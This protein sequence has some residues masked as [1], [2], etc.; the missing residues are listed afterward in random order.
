MKQPKNVSRYFILS[1]VLAALVALACNLGVPAPPAETPVAEQSAPTEAAPS[2]PASS[3]GGGLCDNPLM[4]V[5]LGASWTYSHSGSPSGDFTFTDTITDVRADGFTL[6]AQFDGLTRTQE[7]ACEPNGLKALQLGGGPAGSVTTNDMTAQFQT[8][9]V[10]GVSIPK[11]VAPGMQ[12][13][14]FL[15]MAG[16]T[17]MPGDANAKSEGTFSMS[18]REAGSERVTVP[19]GTFEAIKIE[20]TNTVKIVA[21]FQ[22]MQVPFELSDN[23]LSWYVP[24]VGFVKS[25]GN[26]SAGGEAFTFTMELLSYTIP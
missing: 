6:T 13:E 8:L 22:G 26:S 18:M 4:P 25:I 2:A 15:K 3:A 14:Y 24:G 16:V 5:K 1:L 20:Y 9:E 21:E 7:W 17:A 10:S 19:A 11:T 23:G 12:W